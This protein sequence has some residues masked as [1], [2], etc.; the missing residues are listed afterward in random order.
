M[1]LLFIHPSVPFINESAFSM[2]FAWQQNV[3]TGNYAH[4]FQGSSRKGSFPRRVARVFVSPDCLRRAGRGRRNYLPGTERAARKAFWHLSWQLVEPAVG[5]SRIHCKSRKSRMSLQPRPVR[6]N[7]SFWLL[8]VLW[9]TKKER[10][11]E[12]N[13]SCSARRQPDVSDASIPKSRL[14]LPSLFFGRKYE[15]TFSRDLILMG[16]VR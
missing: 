13:V 11:I 8:Q 10:C 3:G 12:I 2:G 1:L 14:R 5:P 7:V 6:R 16:D 4:N 15:M 9:P